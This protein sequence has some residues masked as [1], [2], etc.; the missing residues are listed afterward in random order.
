[1]VREIVPP[2]QTA[3]RL[4]MNGWGGAYLWTAMVPAR[5]DD[6]VCRHDVQLFALLFS[7]FSPK[8]WEGELVI[9]WVVGPAGT[10]RRRR[11]RRRRRLRLRK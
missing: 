10:D 8:S 3:T 6:V 5:D 2:R 4:A 11:R 1:M 9:G 7:L